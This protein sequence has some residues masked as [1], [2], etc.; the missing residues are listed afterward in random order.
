[1]AHEEAFR[2]CGAQLTGACYFGRLKGDIDRAPCEG[3]IGPYRAY[4]GPDW[5]YF[6]LWARYFGCFKRGHR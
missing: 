3:D 4:S 6:R 5:Q 1:M 2:L